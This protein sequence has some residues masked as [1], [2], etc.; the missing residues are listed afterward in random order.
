[1]SEPI[2]STISPWMPEQDRIRLAVLGKLAEE[3]NEL[4][5]RAARS[6]I[7]GLDERDPSTGRTNREEIAREIADVMACIRIVESRLD[8]IADID[9]I[10]SKFTGFR[11]WHRMIEDP[12]KEGE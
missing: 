7:Q 3:C 12:A 11:R 5:G 6:I 8:L 2:N 1:M 4:A 10:G 9:R